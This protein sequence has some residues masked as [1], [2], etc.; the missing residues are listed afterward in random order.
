MIR[1]TNGMSSSFCLHCIF[2]VTIGLDEL[3]EFGASLVLSMSITLMHHNIIGKATL[4]CHNPET[5]SVFIG[6]SEVFALASSTSRLRFGLAREGL[7][8]ELDIFL[9]ISDFDVFL[10]SLLSPSFILFLLNW[11][12]L[13][14]TI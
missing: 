12:N 6:Y 8:D 14:F 10:P 9:S 1:P 4:T 7:L 11:K 2:K 13:C 3:L 5:C